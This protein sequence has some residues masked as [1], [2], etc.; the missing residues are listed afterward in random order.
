MEVT[1]CQKGVLYV[2]YVLLYF[3]VCLKA[4][5]RPTLLDDSGEVVGRR[6]SR[7]RSKGTP[8]FAVDVV[9]VVV[10]VVVDV[11]PVTLVPHGWSLSLI[12]GS[13]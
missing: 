3:F 10:V 5:R 7:R 13:K 12:M 11:P 2:T 4:Q 9:V 8:L 1:R 6:W